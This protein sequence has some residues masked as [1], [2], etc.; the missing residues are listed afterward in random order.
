MR[1]LAENWAPVGALA[2]SLFGIAVSLGIAWWQR[3]PK[4]LDYA[5]VSSAGLQPDAERMRTPLKIDY[6]GVCVRSPWLATIRIG[7]TGRRA[8][9]AGDFVE[10]IRVRYERNA[11]F[12]GYVTAASRDGLWPEGSSIWPADPESPVGNPD[13]VVEIQPVLM[14]PG[15]WFELQLLSDGSPGRIALTAV[16]P[17]QARPMRSTLQLGYWNSKRGTPGMTYLAAIVI[18]GVTAAVAGRLFSWE[19]FLFV[20]FA[21][22]IATAVL[23]P[24]VIEMHRSQRFSRRS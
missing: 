5:V 21:A 15:E 7:N 9:L 23:L 24:D 1:W 20:F 19:A 4:Q 13:G 3:R 8:I 11:P 12:D 22:L 14:N 2:L 10:P 18:V 16:F 17:D 6:N